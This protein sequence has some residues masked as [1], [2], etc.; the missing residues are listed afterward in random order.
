MK[1]YRSIALAAMFAGLLA[2]PALAQTTTPQTEA[3]TPMPD[4]GVKKAA[5]APVKHVH[6]V[7]HHRAAKAATPAPGTSK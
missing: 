6:H 2:V 5:P 7:S 1:Y 4:A 3:S